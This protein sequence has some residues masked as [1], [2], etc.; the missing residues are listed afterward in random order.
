MRIRLLAALAVTVALTVLAGCTGGNEGAGVKKRE[1]SVSA[2]VSVREAL[3]EIKAS[4]S[5][6][7]RVTIDINYGS[8]GKLQRQI[9]QGAPVDIFL[10]AGE[11]QM[12][13]LQ[14]KGLID[15]GARKNLL[16]NEL[17]LITPAGDESVSG[18]KDLAGSGVA[19]ISIG[20][21][22]TVPA[23]GYARETLMNLGIWEE[24]KPKLVLAGDVRQVLA[25]V[26]T[27]N[28][29]AGIVYRTD[30]MASKRVRV[31]AEAESSLHS[32]VTY[33]VTLTMDGRD[34]GPAREFLQYLAGPE[35]AETFK[36]Y[37][38]SPPADAGLR[39]E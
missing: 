16:G 3:E 12:D 29:R 19:R 34:K 14:K 26:E 4:Y 32:Q 22:D 10:P 31:A 18:F 21:P 23:G 7:R 2:A 6:S 24:V 17:V 28:V 36:R 27:G 9:E 30:A 15:N 5:K 38:F 8:S 13:E 20:E 25:F 35:A 33:P 1:I 11:K 37:G 39:Q